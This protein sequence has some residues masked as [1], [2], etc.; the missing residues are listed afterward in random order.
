MI[1]RYGGGWRGVKPKVAAEHGAIGCIIYSDP[2]GDG[3]YAGRSVSR[4]GGWRPKE[5]VQRGS[6]MDTE[7]PGDPL[8]PGVGATANAKRLAMKDAKTITKIPVLPI[9]YADAL[10]LLSALQGPVAPGHVARRAADHLPRRPGTRARASCGELELGHQADLRRDRDAPWLDRRGSVGDPRQSSRRLGQRRRGSHLRT[11]GDAGGGARDGRAACARLDAGAH[12][13]LLRV[14]R[15]GAGTARLGGMGRDASRR[16]AAARGRLHQLR[17]ERAR[18]HAARR[19]AG[20]RELHQR[21]G[22]RRRAIR[23]PT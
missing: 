1:A 22:A 3:Y 17:Y 6:V 19:H 16:T 14:G 13:H 5:G 7:Y 18:L 4:A 21:R 10:P 8:T 2:K 23:K 20:S 12:H 9:S 15:R 11:G